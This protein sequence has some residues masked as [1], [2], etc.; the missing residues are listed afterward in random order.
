[1]QQS[2]WVITLILMLGILAVFISVYINSKEELDYAPIQNR[3]YSIR[4]KFF[5]LLLAAFLILS[6]LTLQNLPYAAQ[7]ADVSDDVQEIGVTGYQWYW[8]LSQNKVVANKPV[9]FTVKSGDVNHG[10]GIYN[11]SLTL[12]TQVQSMPGYDNK[13]QYTFT[14]KG[15][16]QVMCLEYCGMAHHAMI[17]TLEVIEAN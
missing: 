5:W 7:H 4:N 16:Y 6:F 15:I 11:E 14:E 13:I 8:E 10:M 17:A 12:L 1:M 3:F 2:A 9:L